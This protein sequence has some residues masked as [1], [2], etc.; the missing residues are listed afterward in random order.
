MYQSREKLSKILFYSFTI[1]NY[2]HITH[3]PITK[4]RVLLITMKQ[5]SNLGIQ[6]TNS[7]SVRNSWVYDK[8]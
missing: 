8:F 2:Q 6:N 1:T 3:L 4:I 5:W 7:L